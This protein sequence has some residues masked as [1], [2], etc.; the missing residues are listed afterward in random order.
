MRDFDCLLSGASYD[1]CTAAHIVPYSRDD[2]SRLHIKMPRF[3]LTHLC[4]QIYK[5]YSISYLFAVSAG[6][7]LSNNRHKTSDNYAWSLY[8]RPVCTLIPT[9]AV[10]SIKLKHLIDRTAA[11][12]CTTSAL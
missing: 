6:L 4:L 8:Y 10:V 1:E 3:L 12:L 2:V 7:L 11:L 9:L 5:D